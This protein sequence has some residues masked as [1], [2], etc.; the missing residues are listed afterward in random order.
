M[1]YQR[2]VPVVPIPHEIVNE[3][4]EEN[5]HSKPKK[6]FWDHLVNNVL[7]GHVV[8]VH[9]TVGTP[10]TTFNARGIRVQTK[11]IDE[12]YYIRLDPNQNNEEEQEE[13]V[14]D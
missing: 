9:I 7:D 3:W 11:K 14:Q 13:D 12:W 6:Y 8:R 2:K 4:P 1:A 10:S 5:P